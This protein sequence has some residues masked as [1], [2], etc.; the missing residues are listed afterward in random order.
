MS[1]FGKLATIFAKRILLPTVK[2]IVE[3]PKAPLTLDAAKD[4]L[5]EAAKNEGVRQ[6]GKRLGS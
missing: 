5:L 2:A 1:L 4:A 6:V 3:N